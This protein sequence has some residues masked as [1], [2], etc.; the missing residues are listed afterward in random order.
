MWYPRR[1][2]NSRLWL[3]RPALYPLSYRGTLQPRI[4]CP[5]GANKA[6]VGRCRAFS[7]SLS[8]RERAEVRDNSP[9][10]GSSCGKSVC[11]ENP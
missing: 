8:P 10:N 2:S 3:R 1:E 5:I 7:F 11:V 6:G 4:S 9:C